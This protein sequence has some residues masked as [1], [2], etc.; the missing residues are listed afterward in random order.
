MVIT[1]AVVCYEISY[2]LCYFAHVLI[3][4]TAT[5]HTVVLINISVPLRFLLRRKITQIAG[6]FILN[7]DLMY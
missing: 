6:S 1:L 7:E 4:V 5:I 2:L 3:M